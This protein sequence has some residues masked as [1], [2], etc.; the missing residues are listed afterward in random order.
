[1]RETE[2]EKRRIKEL[3][4]RNQL[5]SLGLAEEREEF[6]MLIISTLS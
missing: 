1:M 3:K 5:L 2:A 6:G 4:A